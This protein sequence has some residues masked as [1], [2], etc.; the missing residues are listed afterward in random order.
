MSVKLSNN[1]SSTLA[2]AITAAATTIT[3]QAGDGTRFPALAA[4]EWFPLTLVKLVS[5]VP[6]YEIVRVT[7]RSG[8]SLTATRAQEGTVATTF[9][10]GDRVEL[11]ATAAAFDDFLRNGSAATLASL[12]VGDVT[13]AR[14]KGGGYAYSDNATSNAIN[15]ANGASQ[16][17]APN[18]GAQTLTI[19]G[20]PAAGTMGELMIE[21]VNLGAATITWPTIQWMK[22]DGTFT[23]TF[24]LS[25]VTLK[26][27]GV[28]FVALWTRDGGATIYGK[29][30]R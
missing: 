8:D 10:A 28:D 30:I 21:G 3:V 11:R 7:A 14:L 26:T 16:R 25:G 23:T 22:A 24:S 2:S 18:T 17:W 20:W 19:S 13:G 5:G 15:V 27:S 4:G 9:S 6:V 12:A 29:V 1:G